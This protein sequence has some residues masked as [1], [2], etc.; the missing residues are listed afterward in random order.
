MEELRLSKSK[1]NAYLACPH[2]YFLGYEL[3]LWPLKK[4][5]NLIAGLVAHM[6]IEIYLK[7]LYE[8]KPFSLSGS[9]EVTWS[10]YPQKITDANEADYQESV[11]LTYALAELFIS[12]VKVQPMMI[13]HVFALPV[14]NLATG[15]VADNLVWTGVMDHANCREEGVMVCDIKTKAKKG[16]LFDVRTSFELTGYAYAYRMITEKRES[17]VSLINLI[18]TKQPGLQILEDYR[19]ERDFDL[20]FQTLTAVA[21][22]IRAKRFYRSPGFHCGYC[23]YKPLCERNI[24]EFVKIFGEQAYERLAIS[25]VI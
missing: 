6:L 17:G 25:D 19:D 22:G 5:I 4:S 12:R 11:H 23:D 16:A 13:E 1:V 15:Q 7:R 9:H 14:V 18:K 3:K 24:D 21:D 8:N 2:K 10:Q 20:F